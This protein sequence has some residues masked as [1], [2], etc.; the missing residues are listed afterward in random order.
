VF[1]RQSA[2]ATVDGYRWTRAGGRQPLGLGDLGQYGA[3]T[4]ASADGGVVVGFRASPTGPADAVMLSGGQVTTLPGLAGY[5]DVQPRAQDVSADGSIIAGQQTGI[6]ADGSSVLVAVRWAGGA[7]TPLGSVGTGQFKYS[8]AIGVSRDGS[9]VVGIV[10]TSTLPDSAFRWTQATGMV[11]LG[12]PA[13]FTHSAATKIS[14]D[15]GTVIGAAFRG[16]GSDASPDEYEAVRFV[17][18]DIELLGD[19]PGGPLFSI[20]HGVSADGSVIVGRSAAGGTTQ[21]RDERAFVWDAAHGMRD[22][23]GVLTD[24]GADLTGWTLTSAWGVSDDG[25]TI[26]GDAINPAG[27]REAFVAVVPEPLATGVLW[28]AGAI[29]LMGRRRR[30]ANGVAR[31]E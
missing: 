21:A 14:A 19:L 24:L 23:A 7:A 5:R 26:A 10:G 31:R 16:T 11:A 28:A 1:G 25:R 9:A 30:R 6:A 20:A 13:G 2:G 22:L 8:Q 18:G 15:G 12:T 17:G 29:E 27:G 4:A 3:V